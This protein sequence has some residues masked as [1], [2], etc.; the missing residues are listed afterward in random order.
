MLSLTIIF[1]QSAVAIY[2]QAICY[3]KDKSVLAL[4]YANRSAVLF[5]MNEFKG[6]LRDIQRALETGYPDKLTYKLQERKGRSCLKLNLFLDAKEAFENTLELGTKHILDDT[7]KTTFVKDLE[8]LVKFTQSKTSTK[9]K[10]I[11]LDKDF[12][13]DVSDSCRIPK[14]VGI[15]PQMPSLSKAVQIVHNSKVQGV[16]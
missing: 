1:F 9:S 10:S 13:E 6:V 8:K 15:N 11:K 4:A 3:A 5:Q 2:N 7:K 14:L 16:P 12:L